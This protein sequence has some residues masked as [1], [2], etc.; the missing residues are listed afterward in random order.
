MKI[1]ININENSTDTEIVI[2]SNSLTPEIERIIAALRMLDSQITVS[3]N[4]ES[5]ILDVAKIAYIESVDRKTFVYTQDDCFESKLKLYEVEEQLCQGEFLRISKSS[6]VQL[7]FIRS[8]KS[9]LNRKIRLT[10][11]NGEQI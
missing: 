5:Y 7:K 1:S 3:K 10:L 2:N 4:D 6:L 9:E 8:L 11:E